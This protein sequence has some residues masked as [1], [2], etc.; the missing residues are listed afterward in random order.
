MVLARL[1]ELSGDIEGAKDS[2]RRVLELSP[3][4]PAAANNLAWILAN[5]NDPNDLGEA[6][7]LAQAAKEKKP[8]DANFGDTLGWV[9]YKQR[10]Y[11]IAALEF[12]QAIE[13]SP[14]NPQF[15][16]HLALALEAQGKKEEALNA[17]R[18]SLADNKSFKD[19]QSA[20]QLHKKLTGKKF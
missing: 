1:L 20:E 17:V 11:Y 2:Y 6:M 3:G 13:K 12:Q 14:N 19:R 16:Y 10:N 7:G 18:K 8:A 15:H 9:H 5:G 4:Y